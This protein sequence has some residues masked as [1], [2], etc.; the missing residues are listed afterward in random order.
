MY[1]KVDKVGHIISCLESEQSQ[2]SLVT[3]ENPKGRGCF[4]QSLLLPKAVEE[5]ILEISLNA[6]LNTSKIFLSGFNI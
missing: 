6:N 3:E 4:L 2:L 5:L 1:F